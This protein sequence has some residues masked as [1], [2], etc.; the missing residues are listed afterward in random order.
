MKRILHILRTSQFTEGF[1]ERINKCCNNQEHV[2]LIFQGPVDLKS[3]YLYEENV[4]CVIC[5]RKELKK[6]GVEIWFDTF[7]KIIYHGVFEP[8]VIRFFNENENLLDKL[9]L[10]FWGGDIPLIG[11][12][13]VKIDK[14]KLI[15]RARAILTI[16]DSDYKKITGIYN[17]SGIHMSMKYF[18]SKRAALMKKK[19]IP[20][21][22]Q[23][24]EKIYIQIGNSATETNNH[25]MVLDLLKKFKSENICI[26]LPLAYGEMEYAKKVAR[27]GKKIFGNKIVILHDYLPLEEYVE[28]ISRIN[29]GL[30]A[31]TRQQALGSIQMLCANG[32]KLFFKK[33]TQVDVYMREELNC[34]TFYIE[35]I[36]GMNF[37][38][39]VSMPL[40][41]Q[42]NNSN[43]IFQL[44]EDL[45]S[46]KKWNELFEV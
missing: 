12:K 27:Y 40:E 24:K 7:D 30:F 38:E 14:M 20:K 43:K 45:K 41:L 32:S 25:I 2:F 33:G 16:L 28:Y 8:Y 19:L 17:P 44:L 3:D 11:D 26:V 36:E 4:K 46:M 5:L 37:N 35:D 39:F 6:P 31:M 15:Q 21:P 23:Y 42:Q 1:V 29:I 9:Y 18:D 10:Y 22:I 34:S 13:E